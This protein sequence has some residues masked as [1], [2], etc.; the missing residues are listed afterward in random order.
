MVRL[1]L[2]RHAKS[3][4]SNIN[5]RDHDRPLNSRG[6]HAGELVG[7]HIAANAIFPQL[8]L[9]STA[10]RTRQTLG[11]ILP[12]MNS[13]MRIQILRDL[14]DQS[15]GDYVDIL[16]ALGGSH[17]TVM[18]I[19][20][21]NAIQDTA[22]E[23]AGSGDPELLAQMETKYPTGALAMIDFDAPRWSQIL[24]KQGRLTAFYRPRHLEVVSS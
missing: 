8:V 2:L 12:H 19:G 3:D 21:N 5:L 17:T 13:E 23:L 24:P 11:C 15:E 20:H 9:C 7:K 10:L 1:M 6:W 18:I 14:Y 4:W 16:S 22:I